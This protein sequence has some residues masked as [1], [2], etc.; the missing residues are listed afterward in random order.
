M[1]E[2]SLRDAWPGDRWWAV[3]HLV[4]PTR[5]RV[6]RSRPRPWPWAARAPD[7]IKRVIAAPIWTRVAEDEVDGSVTELRDDLALRLRRRE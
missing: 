6:E 1:R 2:T 5:E 3:H 7:V 4:K